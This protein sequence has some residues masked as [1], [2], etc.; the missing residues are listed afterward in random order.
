MRVVTDDPGPID[1]NSVLGRLV[2]RFRHADHDIAAR[3][4]PA[5][6]R[7]AGHEPFLMPKSNVFYNLIRFYENLRF[8]GRYDEATNERVTVI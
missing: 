8:P 1:T 6:Q 5:K 2:D 3:N 4:G 7:V